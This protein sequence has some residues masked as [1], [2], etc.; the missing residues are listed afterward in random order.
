MHRSAAL[1]SPP[2][3]PQTDAHRPFGTDPIRGRR[4]L[5]LAWSLFLLWLAFLALLAIRYP[6]R[7]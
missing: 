3:T 2:Q 5:L 4:A 7:G 1:Q 6:A